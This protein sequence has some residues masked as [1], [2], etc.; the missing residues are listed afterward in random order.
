MRDDVAYY[1]Q[2]IDI[3]TNKLME[4][5]RNFD[6]MVKNNF[7]EKHLRKIYNR[8]IKVPKEK[9]SSNDGNTCLLIFYVLLT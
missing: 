2:V 3:E 6:L 8:K 9:Y 4:I 5:K 7:F 1:N